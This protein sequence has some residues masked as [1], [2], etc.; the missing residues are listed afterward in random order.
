MTTKEMFVKSLAELCDEKSRNSK[1]YY[2]PVAKKDV[3]QRDYI[4]LGNDKNAPQ[5]Y[6]DA[7]W[8]KYTNCDTARISQT[9]EDMADNINHQFE[10]YIKE[11]QEMGL[12]F[13][14]L[15]EFERG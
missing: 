12:E 14:G 1:L 15:D 11:K 3:F 4:T 6:M 2:E 13:A 8:H 9:L 10:D 7:Y 5:I